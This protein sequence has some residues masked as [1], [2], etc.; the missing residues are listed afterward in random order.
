MKAWQAGLFVAVK[1]KGGTESPGDDLELERWFR[2][3]KGHERKIHGRR[4][5]G[6]RI[7]QEGPTLLLALDAQLGHPEPFTAQELLPYRH[8]QEPADQ[9]EAIQRRKVMRRARSPKNG[10]PS[11]P[12]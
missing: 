3:P 8:A 4:H 12:S 6:V 5:A 9:T 1:G 7:V 2:Q 10:P 11:S